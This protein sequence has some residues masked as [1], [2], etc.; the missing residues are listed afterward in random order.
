MVFTVN[1]GLQPDEMLQLGGVL[2]CF[3]VGRSRSWLL[4]TQA[5]WRWCCWCVGAFGPRMQR[6]NR[7]SSVQAASRTVRSARQTALNPMH[8]APEAAEHV[9]DCTVDGTSLHGRLS[10][11][12][13]WWC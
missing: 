3:I 2:S 6:P 1:L 7:C 12:S 13:W 11:Q 4:V 9:L 10:S 5:V 8:A